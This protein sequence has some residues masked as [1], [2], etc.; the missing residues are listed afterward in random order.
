MGDKPP[1]PGGCAPDGGESI[2]GL[3]AGLAAPAAGPGL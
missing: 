3:L 1:A 2:F